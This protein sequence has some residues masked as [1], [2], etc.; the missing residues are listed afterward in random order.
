MTLRKDK[1]KVIVESFDD[2]RIRAFL[3]VVPHGGLSLDY[4]A[5]EK[6]YR[7]MNA[8]NFT[9]FVRFFVEAGLDINAAGSDGKSLAE[10]IKGHRHGDKYLEALRN[11]GAKVQA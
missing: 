5:L 4:C 8:E 7:G 1:P 6:A 3:Q 9:T 2:E 11:A 10:T